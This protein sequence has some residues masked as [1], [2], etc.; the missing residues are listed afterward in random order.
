MAGAQNV[1]DG[2]AISPSTSTPKYTLKRIEIHM[3]TD[4][5]TWMVIAVLFIIA[6][7]WKQFT[8]WSFGQT[9]CSLSTQWNVIQQYRDMESW[10]IM[11]TDASWSTATT[12]WMNLYDTIKNLLKNDTKKPITN[13]CVIPFMWNVQNR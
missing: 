8:Y 12:W 4:T 13:D 5:C 11:I 2:V 10:H 3:P 1:T 7:K 6:K 9:K